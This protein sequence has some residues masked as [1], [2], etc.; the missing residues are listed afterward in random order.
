MAVDGKPHNPHFVDWLAHGHRDN[1]ER[2]EKLETKRVAGP[3]IPAVL[4]NSWTAAGG[5]YGPVAFRRYGGDILEFR[6]HLKGGLTGTVAFTLPRPYWPTY[7]R[8]FTTDIDSG[9]GL[10]T[11]ARVLIS[12]ADGTVTIYFPVT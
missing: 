1:A 3:W 2:I 11:L 8:S 12:A 10:F 5:S 7:N 4:Q 6:G 9:A